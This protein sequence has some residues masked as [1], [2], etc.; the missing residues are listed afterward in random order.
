MSS[1]IAKMFLSK[2]LNQYF[3]NLNSETLSLSVNYYIK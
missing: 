2:Y 3:E 1:E